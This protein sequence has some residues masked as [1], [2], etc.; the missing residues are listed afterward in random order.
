MTHLLNF[1]LSL[2]RLCVITGFRIPFATPALAASSGMLAV[3][4]AKLLGLEWVYLPVFFGLLSLFG[5]LS[6]EDVRW[7]SGLILP[8]AHLTKGDNPG[9]MGKQATPWNPGVHS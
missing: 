9:I 2:R 4:L 5:V 8:R 3:W 6:R 1:A 7:A